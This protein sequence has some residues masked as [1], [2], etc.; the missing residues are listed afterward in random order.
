MER[1]IAGSAECDGSMH[2]RALTMEIASTRS[3]RMTNVMMKDASESTR[4]PDR[5]N[6]KGLLIA[7]GDRALPFRY[8]GYDRIRE[9]ASAIYLFHMPAF[10][11]VS[12]YFSRGE[13]SRSRESLAK[14]S[15]G[16]WS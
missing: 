7:G 11:F 3:D 8:R 9:A 13:R 5:D 14:L 12:G 1:S 6:L 4:I 15:S 16:S 2:Q 10:L